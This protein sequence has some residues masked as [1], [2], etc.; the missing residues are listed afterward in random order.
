MT[1]A[2]LAEYVRTS[3]GLE[4]EPW[5]ATLV[6]HLVAEAEGAA[7][8]TDLELPAPIAYRPADVGRLLEVPTSTVHAWLELEVLASVVVA[9][10][11]LVPAHELERFVAELAELEGDQ[12]EPESTGLEW[13]ETRPPTTAERQSVARAHLVAELRAHRGEWCRIDESMAESLGGLLGL[14]LYLAG[15]DDLEVDY[16]EGEWW[17]RAIELPPRRR[18]WQR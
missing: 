5:Q 12:A 1:P 9:G 6:A 17:A 8:P 4:L 11:R 14:D 3:T 16:A 13:H 15:V 18:W 7:E 10:V 2:E